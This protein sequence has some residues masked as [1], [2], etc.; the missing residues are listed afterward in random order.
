MTTTERIVTTVC[1]SIIIV[2]LYHVILVFVT[3]RDINFFKWITQ[4]AR[5]SAGSFTYAQC[6]KT[7]YGRILQ[8]LVIS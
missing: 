5:I 7:F 3:K 4:R 8:I 2:T 6:Y 1:L